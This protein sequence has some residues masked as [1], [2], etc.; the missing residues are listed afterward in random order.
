MPYYK[1]TQMYYILFLC[2]EKKALL[3]TTAKSLKHYHLTIKVLTE[4]K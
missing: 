2:Q 1:V 4:D 3:Q